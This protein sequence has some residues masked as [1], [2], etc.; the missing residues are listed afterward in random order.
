[1]V[2]VGSEPNRVPILLEVVKL[3][4]EFKVEREA[5][6]EFKKSIWGTR[7]ID[8]TNLGLISSTPYDPQSPSG[9]IPKLRVRS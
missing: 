9:K 3:M 6:V 2:A 5:G 4:V 1:M 7:V 8:A